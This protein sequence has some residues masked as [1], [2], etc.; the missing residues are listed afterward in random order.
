MMDFNIKWSYPKN[1]NNFSSTQRCNLLIVYHAKNKEHAFDKIKDAPS[2]RLNI[3]NDKGSYIC[4]TNRTFFHARVR[5]MRAILLILKYFSFN[6]SR[7]RNVAMTYRFTHFK[8][9]DIYNSCLNVNL[10]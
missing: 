10:T 1:I 2:N 6:G 9:V 5:K 3:Q 4:F 7:M 8:C